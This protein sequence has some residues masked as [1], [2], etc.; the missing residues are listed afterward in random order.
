MNKRIVFK[1]GSGD[2]D[3]GFPVT[4]QLGE[5]GRTPQLELSRCL[6][7]APDLP[8]LYQQ[9]VSAYHRL[10]G[11][12]TRIRIPTMPITHL[13][14]PEAHHNCREAAEKLRSHFNHWLRQ[15]NI[16][17]LREAILETLDRQTPVRIIIQTQDWILQRL[18]WTVWDFWQRYPHAEIALS[19]L[20]YQGVKPELTLQGT[21][22]ILAVFGEDRGL[23]LAADRHSL[24]RL[25][26]AQITYLE[27]PSFSQLHDRLWSEPWDVFFFAGHSSSAS[28]GQFQLNP[29]ERLN[30]DQLK[31][32]LNRSIDRG[33]KLAIFNSCDGLG[34]AQ[35]L[36]ALNLPQIIVM[37]EQV[38]DR[39]AHQFLEHF[40]YQFSQ[41]TQLYESV[42]LA[43]EK[44]QGLEDRFPCATW[45]PVIFQ[46]PAYLP[47][48]WKKTEV[49]LTPQSN[50]S[51]LELRNRQ[52]LLNK[53]N[54]YWV[55]GVLE[56]SLHG[57]VL[58][59]LGIEERYD[60]IAHPWG[61]VWENTEQMQQFPVT[62]YSAIEKFEALGMGRSLLILGEPGSGK[63][64]TLLELA[65]EFIHR[66][67][68]DRHLPIPVV[69]NLSSWL[70]EQQS[71]LD[72]LIQELYTKYQ[73]PKE[74]SQN[75]I[76]DSALLLLLDGLDEVAANK[77]QACVT[78]LNEFMQNH[79]TLEVVICSRYKDYDQLSQK[80]H[81]LAA[82]Y[83]QPL[84]QDR[85]EQYLQFCGSDL[86][87]L[88]QAMQ[89]DI[90][91]QD[92]AQSPLMLNI[93]ALAYQ[94]MSYDDFPKQTKEQYH[95]HLFDAYIE[96][97]FS[98][99]I[100]E[101]FYSKAQTKNGLIQLAQW[102]VKESQTVFLI[103]RM[104]PSFLKTKSEKLRYCALIAL[105]GGIFS[106][107]GI[108]CSVGHIA[109]RHIGL[110]SGAILGI[111]GGLAG[112]IILMWVLPRIEPVEKMKWS[113]HKMRINLI[114]GLRVGLIAGGFY[115][116]SVAL[117]FNVIY[118]LNMAVKELLI[119]WLSGLNLG[120]MFI[121]LRGLTGG[122][123]NTH[124]VPNQGI[125]L[126][127]RN[128][129]LFAIL[130]ICTLI[131]LAKIVGHPTLFGA[132]AGLLIGLFSPSSIACLQHF[133]LRVIL[134]GSGK[135]PWNYARFLD[136]ATSLIFLQK[137][138]GGYIFIHR[139]LLEHFAQLSLE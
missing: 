109:G 24:D 110:L 7:A 38:P 119:F 135:V 44:L 113:W 4:L 108:G 105:I 40:L 3:R 11:L 21:A 88:R 1:I 131:V 117:I 27:C 19:L 34:L 70:G 81:V 82:I 59:E 20:D 138:G 48:V 121:L 129:S 126:S 2:F 60:A 124:T 133:T 10:A 55:K 15:P 39:V 16:L 41:E 25:P 68:Q 102:M 90:I 8:L 130:G 35:Q 116:L 87:G 106:A 72:W 98:R 118:G 36:A 123:I 54:L 63:T 125:W 107:L 51:R 79:G 86:S 80:L 97:M 136:Y 104:Q 77:R 93:M 92:L 115:A 127:A 75:W 83:L 64:T 100:G 37:R 45:L 28:G 120:V 112:G 50:L 30:L 33:L 84:T 32:A 14:I 5:E 111:A 137:V 23:N 57:Q 74:I 66:A 67:N 47:L 132:I 61:L 99:K 76:D 12:D 53:V 17:D 43:R 65:Q 134:Y 71:I 139:L 91:L 95:T 42:R 69:F 78:A 49:Q 128:A 94:G 89:S 13:G 114:P 22:N 73:I 18:P 101:H 58:L 103:E 52:I 6:D 56:A 62:H 9:W 96:R 29:Q 46:N 85:I 31:Y 26:N 122:D